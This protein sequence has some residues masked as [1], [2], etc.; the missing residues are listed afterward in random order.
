MLPILR[1]RVRLVSSRTFFLNLCRLLEW[2]RIFGAALWCVN[3]NPRYFEYPGWITPLFVSLTFSF[4]PLPQT[5][6]GLLPFGLRELVSLA[7]DF[8]SLRVSPS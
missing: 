5:S 2:I 4:A 8:T 3:P 7:K 6:C 1:P